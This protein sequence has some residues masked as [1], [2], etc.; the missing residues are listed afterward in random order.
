MRDGGRL[1]L[2]GAGYN[3]KPCK[4]HRLL[5]GRNGK[6]RFANAGREHLQAKISLRLLHARD[7]RLQTLNL[8]SAGGSV[9]HFGNIVVGLL[10]GVANTAGWLHLRDVPRRFLHYEATDP[11][12]AIWNVIKSRGA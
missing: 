11:T 8:V 2:V 5:R 10:G 6:N 1:S 4:N 3:G 7:L 12:Q 9:R